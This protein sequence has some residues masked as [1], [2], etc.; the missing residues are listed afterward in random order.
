MNKRNFKSV[1]CLTILALLATLFVGI[2]MAQE[3]AAPALGANALMMKGW[4]DYSEWF[5]IVS[6]MPSIIIMLFIA[7]S[8]H[9]ARPMVLRYLNRMTL[10][11]GAD[12]LWEAWII[13]R[14]VLILAAVG[15]IGIFIVPR[16]QSDWNTGVFMPA[17]A[18]G[19]ITLLY[20]LSTDTDADKKKYMVA[21]G[22]TALTLIAVLVPYSIGSLWEQKGSD[23]FM[24]TYLIPLS[25]HDTIKDVK[26]A[27]DD[28]V[29][30]ALKG[31]NST[32]LIKAQ[33]ANAIRV[34]LGDSLKT[35]DSTKASQADD[36]FTALTNAAKNGNVAGM[37][38]AQS[39]IIQILDDY[40]TTLGVL[41]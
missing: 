38:A 7:L 9:I 3:E 27:M 29:N 36:A 8:L 6:L 14:D 30:A 26:T 37:Q 23:F 25:N 31:D 41:D 13:G 34:R 39:T 15:L 12:I 17:F 33:D 40:D 16:V 22:L 2:A 32:A 35:W 24:D 28:A 4:M 11:L 18:L 5:V 19:I 20:K 21:T 1:F 10:R